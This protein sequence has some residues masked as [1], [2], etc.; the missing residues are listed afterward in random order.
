MPIYS[1]ISY[2]WL[3]SK[4]IARKEDG[5]IGCE[6]TFIYE[7]GCLCIILGSFH[8]KW[9][10]LG[11]NRGRGIGR[12]LRWAIFILAFSRFLLIR[13]RYLL[14]VCQIIWGSWLRTYKFQP[15]SQKSMYRILYSNPQLAS[16]VRHIFSS[17]H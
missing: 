4:L 7:L 12:C 8:L 17:F 5:W 13:L 3:F 9:L 6:L 11:R 16:S 15:E 14:H 2:W 10:G 1:Q